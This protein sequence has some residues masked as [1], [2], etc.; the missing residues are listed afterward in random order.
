[1]PLTV[2]LI[3]ILNEALAK[4]PEPFGT[5]FSIPNMPFEALQPAESHSPAGNLSEGTTAI[6]L[7]HN[8]LPIKQGRSFPSPGLR[9]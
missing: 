5:F 9:I 4:W 1:M 7:I 3:F 8:S 6:T 2:D